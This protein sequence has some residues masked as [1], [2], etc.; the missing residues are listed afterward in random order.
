MFN[1]QNGG[2]RLYVGNLPYAY[3]TEDL[4]KLFAEYGS[5]QDAVVMM[6]PSQK[7]RSKGFGFVTMATQSEADR[8]IASINGTNILGRDLVCNVAKP[9]EPRLSF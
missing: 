4:Y 8:A 5:V 7:D 1:K 3:R 2:V 6:D 9:R